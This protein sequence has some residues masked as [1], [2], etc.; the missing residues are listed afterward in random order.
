MRKTKQGDPN[1]RFLKVEQYAFSHNI[2]KAAAR[3]IGEKAGAICKVGR[4]VL[5]DSEAADEYLRE[6]CMTD[7]K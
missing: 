7:A 5:I 3:K 6:K 2:G 1:G 4:L